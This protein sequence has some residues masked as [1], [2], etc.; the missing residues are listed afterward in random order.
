MLLSAFYYTYDML[1]MFRAPLCPSSRAHD[2]TAY[3]HMGRLILR[4][5][6]VGG[7]VKAGW[8]SVWAEG[9]SLQQTS[10]HQ[11]PKNQKAHVVISGIVVSSR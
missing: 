11:Q 5:L 7:L 4:L 10:Y 3:Y 9:K 8:L 1:N 2:Y 6:M